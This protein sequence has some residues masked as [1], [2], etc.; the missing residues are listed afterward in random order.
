[1][2]IDTLPC[3]VHTAYAWRILQ[4]GLCVC[5]VGGT[6]GGAGSATTA[7]AAGPDDSAPTVYASRLLWWGAFPPTRITAADGAWLGTAL[8]DI[9]TTLT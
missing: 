5:T 1:M 8:P 6:T 7:G 4:G 2:Y 3:E 9:G